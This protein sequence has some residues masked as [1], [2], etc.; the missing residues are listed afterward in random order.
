MA[1]L[2]SARNGSAS[3]P[4]A[5]NNGAAKAATLPAGSDGRLLGLSA[6]IACAFSL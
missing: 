2:T 4:S 5:G 3:S 6:G 1:R